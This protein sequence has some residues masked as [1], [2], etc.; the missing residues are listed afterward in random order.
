ME[1]DK[2]IGKV[3]NMSITEE[4]MLV[5]VTLSPELLELARG[6]EKN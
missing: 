1:L 3:T 6:K 4:G 5:D 2:K